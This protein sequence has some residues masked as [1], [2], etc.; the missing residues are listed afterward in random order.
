[1]DMSYGPVITTS[2][3][4]DRFSVQDAGVPDMVMWAWHS[5][6]LP[7]NLWAARKIVARRLWERV[8]GDVDPNLSG[9]AAKFLGTGRMSGAVLALLTMGLDTA[10]GRFRLDGD[11]LELSWSEEDSAEYFAACREGT[12]R[13]AEELGGEWLEAPFSKIWSNHPLGG[14]PMGTSIDDGVVS[15]ESGEVFGQPGLHVADGSV[16]PGPVGP[17]PSWTIA[18]VAERFTDAMIRSGP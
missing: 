13:V 2:V 6:E 14:V 9:E 18:A 11:D 10:S 4:F 17:N 15:A 7:E 3:D 8:K 5:L 1:M 16:L 12:R